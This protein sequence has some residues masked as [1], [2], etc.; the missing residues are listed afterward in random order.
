MDVLGQRITN[1]EDRYEVEGIRLSYLSSRVLGAIGGIEPGPLD[2]L[3]N[4]L[5]QTPSCVNPNHLEAVAHSENVR[6][7]WVG[8]KLKANR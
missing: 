8:R 7:G 5:C 6:R 3:L 4:H 1:R 2:A